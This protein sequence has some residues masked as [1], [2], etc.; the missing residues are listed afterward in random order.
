[1]RKG[2]NRP[3]RYPELFERLERAGIRPFVGMILGLDQDTP[4]TLAETLDFLLKHRVQNVFL[5]I[6]TPL[7][8]TDVYDEME[9]A[10]RIID[11]DWSNYDVGHVVF[12][13]TNFTP[14]Q[15]RQTYWRMY[16]RI[17]SRGAIAG[18]L[19]S[20]LVS[21]RKG[22]ARLLRDTSLQVYMRTHVKH[23]ENPLSMGIGRI[24][25]REGIS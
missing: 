18:R 11:R 12:Q 5:N 25:G 14:E 21:L 8:G 15:L 4:E 6:F 17:Y 23:A 13:P 22:P 7:P 9:A 10:G 24:A 1:M 19:L 3:E 20:D 2:F 16:E